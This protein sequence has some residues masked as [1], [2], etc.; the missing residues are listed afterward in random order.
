MFAGGDERH[1]Q[2]RDEHK[3]SLPAERRTQGI[4]Y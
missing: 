2:C 4:E 3:R 1:K